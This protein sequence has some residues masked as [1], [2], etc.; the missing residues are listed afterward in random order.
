MYFYLL[1]DDDDERVSV[2]DG[3]IRWKR[4]DCKLARV[5]INFIFKLMKKQKKQTK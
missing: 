5:G 1:D 2:N 3:I 4:M